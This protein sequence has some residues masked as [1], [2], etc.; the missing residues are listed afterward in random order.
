VARQSQVIN[1]KAF[2]FAVATE[3]Q[4]C[5]QTPIRP[6]PEVETCRRAFGSL[7]PEFT[8]DLVHAAEK[9][10]D[11]ILELERK[12]FLSAVPTE[13]WIATDVSGQRGDVRDVV[14]ETS[15]GSIGISCKNNHA[16]FKHSRLSA[17]MD[18]VKKWGLESA[19]CSDEY[20]RRV[21]PIFAELESIRRTSGAQT[22]WSE[23][24]DVAT[25]FYWPVLDAFA[26][27]L[28]R[29]SE[30]DSPAAATVSKNLVMYV[31]G[32]VDFYKVIRLSES[33][34]VQ[35]FN[36]NG[37]LATERTHGPTHVIKIDRLDGGQYSK[38]VRL[39]RGFTFNF[40]IHN[41]SSRVEPSLKF[42]ITA[43]SL[44]PTEIYVNHLRI[45][46]DS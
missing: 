34:T 39:N 29:L 44:P 7:T 10:V 1:G 12:K 22:L 26:K 25:R 19:G 3:F 2:E 13:I 38:T 45:A 31:V 43:V 5:L 24:P 40:R 23:L 14:V 17:R 27:E 37:S 41:A 42:D 28:T 18:F 20:W 15:N 4:R 30:P 33:V 16:A 46:V 35:G 8:N 21:R 9:A 6:G 36:F 32:R 11:H